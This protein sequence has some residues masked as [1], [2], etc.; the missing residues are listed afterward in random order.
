ML[1]HPLPLFRTYLKNLGTLLHF[2]SAYPLLAREG[3]PSIVELSQHTLLPGD[4]KDGRKSRS[5]E[6]VLRASHLQ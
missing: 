4:E 6:A 5:S 1:W 2:G 3:M